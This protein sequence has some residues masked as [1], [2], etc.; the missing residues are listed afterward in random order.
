MSL[1]VDRFE[2]QCVRPKPGKVLIAGSHI[3]Q[4]KPDR[5]KLHADALGVDMQAGEG[6]DVVADL[7]K[8]D[9][10]C[11]AHIECMSLLEH[12][13]R[14]WLLA[15]NLER[16]LEPAGTIF[17]TVPFI[18]KLHG[19]PSDY[20]RFTH[21][22]IRLLFPAVIWTHYAYAAARELVKGEEVPWVREGDWPHGAATE[23][24]M[25]GHK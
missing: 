15:A 19:Y 24:C 4:Q 8:D 12:V 11:F 2:K 1:A 3:W 16:M 7:E 20:W 5:R 6:V 22:G 14:P 13:K 25:F 23:V 9:V 10:G 18:W 21:E 17:V